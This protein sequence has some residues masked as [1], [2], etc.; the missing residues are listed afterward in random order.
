MAQAV[1]GTRP[2]AG[3]W[4]ATLAGGLAAGAIDI[5]YAFVHWAHLGPVR[6]LQ[7]IAAGLLGA[8]AFAGGMA[9]AALGGVLHV[10][11]AIA[12]AA[13]FVSAAR[14]SAL[15]RRHLLAAGLAY[16]AVIYFGMRLVVIPLSRVPNPVFRFELSE[17]LGHLLGV[18]LLIALAAR[19]WAVPRGNIM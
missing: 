5:V 4:K 16:G 1:A 8:D 19:Q 17:F 3:Y 9:T 6:I 12:M 18:G 13:I 7:S 11:M 2:D 10:A 14:R 15:L